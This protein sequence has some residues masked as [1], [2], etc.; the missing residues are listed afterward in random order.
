VTGGDTFLEAAAAVGR[1]S[2]TYFQGVF[3]AE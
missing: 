3:D 2:D 1:F